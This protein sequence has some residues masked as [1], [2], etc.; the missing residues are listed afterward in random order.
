ME[1]G[2]VA[3][4]AAV[5]RTEPH[6]A[7][8]DVVAK[9]LADWAPVAFADLAPTADVEDRRAVLGRTRDA[10]ID[11]LGASLIGAGRLD[12]AIATLQS[13]LIDQPDRQPRVGLLAIALHRHGASADAVRLLDLATQG[14]IRSSGIA[15]APALAG[16]EARI[17]DGDPALLEPAIIRELRHDPSRTS[18]PGVFWGR[19]AAIEEISQHLDNASSV[20]I[21]GAAGNGKSALL[22]EL[23][24]R[25]D[26]TVVAIRCAEGPAAPYEPVL[27]LVGALAG[28]PAVA[29]H[30]EIAVA[31]CD[32]AAL[33]WVLP[34]LAAHLE[35]DGALPRRELRR[36]RADA[37]LVQLLGEL[38]AAVPLVMI[39]DDLHQA[40]AAS[41]H[42][43]VQAAATTPALIVAARRP[44]SDDIDPKIR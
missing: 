9:L 8:P 31:A 34:D 20:L 44:R 40:P 1:L 17:L 21:T 26:E 2:A 5:L 3:D 10:V 4:A 19:V 6:S 35:I 37:A 7:I 14:A 32:G 30:F 13:A 12:E 15:I 29:P 24:H 16:L 27:D 11:H 18:R 22:S 25:R 23:T 41:L 36:E 28:H 43:V 38:A 33:S 39:I 42:V